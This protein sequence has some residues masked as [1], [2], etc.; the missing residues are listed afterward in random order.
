M[1]SCLRRS[2]LIANSLPSI[3][4]DWFAARG[5][6]VREHQLQMLEAA[7]AGRHALLTAPTGAGKTLAGF[8]P[9]LVELVEDEA[10]VR[11]GPVEGSV[12]SGAALREAQ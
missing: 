9:T 3:L 8:L 2:T 6:A 10:S 12:A 7:R 11:A 5:W 1:G 4:T